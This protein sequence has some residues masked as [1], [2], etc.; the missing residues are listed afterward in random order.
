MPPLTPKCGRGNGKT[1]SPKAEQVCRLGE[2]SEIC[3]PFTSV[4]SFS[5]HTDRGEDFI[6]RC[7]E[8]LAVLD[9]FCNDNISKAVHFSE[10]H[11]TPS[12]LG[13]ALTEG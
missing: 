6:R 9:A 1:E 8:T 4:A 2:C 11:V 5:V 7:G 13:R 12:N 3:P 10:T